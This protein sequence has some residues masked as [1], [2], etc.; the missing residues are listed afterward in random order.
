MSQAR[1][2]I[3]RSFVALLLAL[4]VTSFGCAEQIGDIDR[5][6]P[7]AIAKAD[8]KGQWYMV[9]TTTEVPYGVSASFVGEMA[10]GSNPKILWDIQEKY[11]IAYPVSE[12]LEGA[13]KDHHKKVIRKYWDKDVL[14]DDDIDNDFMYVYVGQ[15]IAAF[16]VESH[17]DVKRKYNAQTGA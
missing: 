15:P 2:T 1:R 11:L 13:E 16:N 6:Q 8:F 7:N 3:E 10:F 4:T 12:I 17:F 5:T 14:L 9:R